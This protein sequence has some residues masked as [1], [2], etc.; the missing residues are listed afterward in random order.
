MSKDNIQL[1]LVLVAEG[2]YSC[3]GILLCSTCALFVSILCLCVWGFVFDE[4][5]ISSVIIIKSFPPP[6]LPSMHPL[7][8]QA[9]CQDAGM[10]LH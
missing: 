8:Q 3:M 5:L 4:I 2:F 6:S 9:G 7:T 10:L 1:Q